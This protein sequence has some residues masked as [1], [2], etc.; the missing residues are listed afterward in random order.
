[1]GILSRMKQRATEMEKSYFPYTWKDKPSIESPINS[2]NL[3]HIESGINELDNRIVVLSKDK[4]EKT[5]LANVFI[6]FEFNEN[7]GVMTFTRFDGSKVEKDTAMEKIALN[8]Y[9]EGDNFVLELADGSKQTVSLSKFID[10]YTFK[11][12]DVIRM[13]VNGKEVSADIPDGKITLEK[14]EA[15]V[16]SAIRQYVLD[17]QTAK[18]VAE[19]AASTAQGWAIGGES[20]EKNNA[21]YFSDQSKRYAVG[22]VE[23]GDEADNA[24]YYC[25]E[26]RKAAEQAAGSAGFDGTAASVSAVDTHDLTGAGVGKK[27]TVQDLLDAIVQKMVEKVVTSDT[28][29]TVLAKYLVNNGLTTEAGKFGLDAAFGK[30]LQDQITQQNS[31]IT[32]EKTLDTSTLT[33]DANVAALSGNWMR[34]GHQVTV[35]AILNVGSNGIQ[36]T[37]TFTKEIPSEF[38][39]IHSAGFLLFNNADEN[40]T[41]CA[42]VE[43]KGIRATEQAATPGIWYASASWSVR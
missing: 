24:Q 4:A 35:Y 38:L 19:Q 10:T 37:Q 17:A 13:N 14:L 34:L 3:N 5:E 22:G 27:S 30:N 9:L 20:F 31:N 36:R 6:N 7:S 39:P 23:D 41:F 8:C 18:G 26:A 40:K 42:Y 43:Q 16:M 28:F 29:Q 11:S 1:M 15:T 32:F 33:L 25:E 21:K 12:T 2:V